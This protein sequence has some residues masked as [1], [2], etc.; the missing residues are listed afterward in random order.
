MTTYTVPRDQLIYA[1]DAHNPPAL[2]V[3]DGATLTFQTRDCFE[4]QIQDEGAPFTALDWN[5]VNPA[6]GPVYVEGAEPGDA[7]A[8]EIVKIE[9]G[10]QSVMVTGPGLGVEGQSLTEPSVRVYPIEEGHVTVAGVKLPLRP[11]IGVIGTAPA[12]EAVSNGTPGDHGGNMD[13]K[14]IREGSTLWLPVNVPG[15]LLAL[16]D[17]HAGMGDGEVSVCGLEVPGEVT[18]RVRLVKA[19]PYPLPMVQTGEH[20]Y[21]VASALTLDEAAERAARQMSTFLQ[22]EAGLSRADAIGLMS[23][24]GNLQISQVVDPLK[25]CRFELSLDILAQLGVRPPAS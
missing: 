6:T 3:P 25:T 15:G 23:A 8:I 19:C 2:R 18:L 4:D 1:M 21:T 20:L 7:L 24:A 10:P 17:L 11:M 22:A 5:R 16:G 9:V 13:T 12:G 14:V